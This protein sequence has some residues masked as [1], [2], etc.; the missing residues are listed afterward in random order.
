MSTAANLV[1]LSLPLYS[2]KSST[3]KFPISQRTTNSNDAAATLIKLSPW[4]LLAERKNQGTEPPEVEFIRTPREV[5][6][7]PNYRPASVPPE[8][9]E[10][11]RTPE[12]D[13]SDTPLEF[14]TRDPPPLGRPRPD[15]GPDFP[16]PP[17]GPPPTGPEVPVPPPSRPS[18]PEVDPLLPPDLILPPSTRSDYVPPP[19]IPPEIPL[20]RIPPDIPPTKGPSFVF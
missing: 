6:S 5:P 11:P 16:K 1:K 13:P 19:F 3:A 4:R 9:P 7:G 15:P 12:V 20:P 2:F 17:L 10:I 18:P 14:T 8:V